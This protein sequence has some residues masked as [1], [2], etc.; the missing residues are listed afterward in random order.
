MF[1]VMKIHSVIIIL[2]LAKVVC[3]TGGQIEE[4]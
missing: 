3:L 4:Y 2:E 1:M